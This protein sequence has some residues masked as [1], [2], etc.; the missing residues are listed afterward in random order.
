VCAFISRRALRVSTSGSSRRFMSA[1]A[2][3]SVFRRPCTRGTWLC[4]MFQPS[5]C[6]RSFDRVRV[7]FPPLPVHSPRPRSCSPR[8]DHDR[9]HFM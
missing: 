3:R 8:D 7:R 5:R 1:L 9:V 6:P 4:F 2:A